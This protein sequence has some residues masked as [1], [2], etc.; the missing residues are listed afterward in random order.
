MFLSAMIQ[1]TSPMQGM[2]EHPRNAWKGG[3]CDAGYSNYH[4]MVFLNSLLPRIYYL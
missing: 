2:L 4:N 3:D 1:L